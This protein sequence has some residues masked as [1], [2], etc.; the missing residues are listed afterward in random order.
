M[1]DPHL[2]PLA[3]TRPLRPRDHGINV[4]QQETHGNGGGASASS[5]APSAPPASSG[6]LPAQH[7]LSG[8]GSSIHPPRAPVPGSDNGGGTAS[9][10]AVPGGVHSSQHHGSRVGHAGSSVSRRPPLH[11][12]SQAHA[13]SHQ[14]AAAHPGSA[15]ASATPTSLGAG[16]ATHDEETPGS[17]SHRRGG[18]PK[19]VGPVSRETQ[20]TRDKRAK[21]SDTH[22]KTRS[23]KNME[24]HKRR[25]EGMTDDEKKTFHANQR[26]K[27]RGTD[28]EREGGSEGASGT[29]T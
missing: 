11:P 23:Q 8:S 15:S 29:A 1:T 17:S 7:R 13:S 19:I 24:A 21:H 16:S 27:R 28:D 3:V 22:K 2:P 20:K 5:R 4:H 9:S 25:L 12:P 14:P 26:K 10:S 18:R 6:G